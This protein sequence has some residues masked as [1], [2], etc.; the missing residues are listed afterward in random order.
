MDTQFFVRERPRTTDAILMATKPA[1]V[2]H[3]T[4]WNHQKTVNFRRLWKLKKQEL[5]ITQ[6]DAADKLGMTQG[7]FSQYLNGHTEMNEKAVMKLAKFLDVPPHV[8]DP[9]FKDKLYL[10]P[11]AVQ[12]QS[13]EVSYSTSNAKK[14]NKHLYIPEIYKGLNFD[15]LVWVSVDSDIKSPESSILIP[16]GSV[17]GLI[18]VDALSHRQLTKTNRCYFEVRTDK[19]A[20]AI[21]FSSAPPVFTDKT[22]TIY[23]ALVVILN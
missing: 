11:V 8:I 4:F 6:K 2:H 5:D 10:P 7:A 9:S 19:Q 21:S 20:F 22:K 18:D 13:V 14:Q 15:E 16:K 17:C 12:L 1:D 3:P 23:T